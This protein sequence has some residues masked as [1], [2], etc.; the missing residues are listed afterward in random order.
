[1]PP[2]NIH[3]GTSGWNFGHWVGAFYPDDI[4]GNDRLPAYAEKFHTVELNNSFYSLPDQ[5]SVKTWT[6]KT[7]EKFVLSCKASRYI[8]HAPDHFPDCVARLDVPMRSKGGKK[9]HL[10]TPNR[11]VG[12]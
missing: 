6:S 2:E 1:M 8:K 11:L 12:H 9:M 10:Q 5:K 7:P 3:I 4:A